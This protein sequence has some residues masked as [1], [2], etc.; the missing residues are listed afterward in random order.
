MDYFKNLPKISYTEGSVTNT[1]RNLFFKI[2]VGTAIK[3]KFLVNYA[4][5][6]GQTLEDISYEVYDDPRFWW[7]VALVN[8]IGD[9][10]Y[11]LP[12]DEATIQT[13]ANEKAKTIAG[14]ATTGGDNTFTDFRLA[15]SYANDYFNTYTISHLT[16]TNAPQTLAILDY[17]GLN[18]VFTIA[19]RLDLVDASAFS[20][21]GDISG[22][23]VGGND[24]VGSIDS[25][26][27]NTVYVNVTS[28]TFVSGNGVD[29]VASYS[30]D[31]TTIS[32]VGTIN[33]GDEYKILNAPLDLA[34]FTVYYDLL[35]TY[36]NDR[37][38]IKVIR[39]DYMKQFLADVT[40]EVSDNI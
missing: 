31:E 5:R 35:E 34:L 10:I 25:I 4:I 3:D 6:D 40:K 28:G 12:L 1:I 39:P 24:G 29:N 18:A 17:D 2:K 7:V 26:S 22:D 8:D 32:L 21:A 20:V 19:E 38:D 13:I 15:G 36:N 11:D 33:V 23:S 27:G 30:A 14:S 37:R 16:G 9:T